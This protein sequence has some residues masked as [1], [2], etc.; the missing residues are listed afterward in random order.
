MLLRCPV[1]LPFPAPAVALLCLLLH[2]TAAQAGASAGGGA[3][4]LGTAPA[5]A[6]AAGAVSSFL[7]P[8]PSNPFGVAGAYVAGGW[9]GRF[10]GPTKPLTPVPQ[11]RRKDT[12]FPQGAAAQQLPMSPQ[13]APAQVAGPQVP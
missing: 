9:D 12:D 4:A 11:T 5:S 3:S 6:A 13:G 7:T 1:S 8:D 10:A 2:C